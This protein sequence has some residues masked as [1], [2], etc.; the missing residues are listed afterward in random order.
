MD[1][2]HDQTSVPYGC[3]LLPVL[4]DELQ[5]KMIFACIPKSTHFQD[6]FINVTGQSFAR[7]VNRAAGWI[8]DTLGKSH[9]FDTL[10]Y[11]G[12]SDIRYGIFLLAASKVGYKVTD[13]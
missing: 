13:S 5:P 2:L 7:A 11:L 6:G 10:A 4:V 3:R 9:S 12:P 8:Q 1:N